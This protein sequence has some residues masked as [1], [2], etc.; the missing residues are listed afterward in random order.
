MEEE[1]FA[2]GSCQADAS[3]GAVVPLHFEC[4]WR[5]IEGVVEARNL[6]GW[7]LGK[8]GRVNACGFKGSPWCGSVEAG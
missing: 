6:A 7:S 4:L 1:A 3:E 8:K 2:D 5:W